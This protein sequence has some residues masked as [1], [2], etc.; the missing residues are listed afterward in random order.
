MRKRLF[1]S[2]IACTAGLMLVFSCT[3]KAP[4]A[5]NPGEEGSTPENPENPENP[6][7][8][9][10][11]K[12]PEIS[13]LS[14]SF[15]VAGNDADSKSLE[16]IS[17]YFFGGD[18]VMYKNETIVSSGGEVRFTAL[19]KTDAYFIAGASVPAESGI[20]RDDFLRMSIGNDIAHDNSAPEF[21]AAQAY[22]PDGEHAPDIVEFTRRTARIDMDTRSDAAMSISSITLKNVPSSA[23][24]FSSGSPEQAEKLSYSKIFDTPFSGKAEDLFRIYESSSPIGVVIAGTYG[25][26][27]VH[28]ETEI[29]SVRSNSIYTL[30]LRNAGSSFEG[31]FEISPWKDGGT[32]EGTPDTEHRILIDREYSEFPEGVSADF[33]SNAVEVPAEG[34]T[35]TLAFR[36][37]SE[38]RISSVNGQTSDVTVGDIQ[39]SRTETGIVSRYTVSIKPQGKGRLGYSVLMHLR[40]ALLDDTY[41]FVDIRVAQSPSQIHTVSLGG[42]VW[43]SFNASTRNLEDQVYTL[44]G[45]DVED[46]YR[47]DWTYCIGGLFQFGRMYMYIPWNSYNP[48]NDL[49]NQKQDIP[50]QS[51]THM[52]CPEGY[53]VPSPQ[54]W[55]SLLPA[56]TQVP[57]TYVTGAGETVRAELL[58]SES[59]INVPTGVTGT[60]RYVKLT[61]ESDGRYLIIPLAGN[62]GDKSTTNNPGFGQRAVMW[63][64]DNSGQYGGWARTHSIILSGSAANFQQTS[65][66]MEAFASVRCLKK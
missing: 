36:A 52:P 4:V 59:A 13:E 37:A 45:G 51:D 42:S 49:G 6:E 28:I 9:G 38:I 58:T 21:L 22:L 27:P 61:A 24:P 33:S 10:S 65:L 1:R 63:T 54:E 64:N 57:G 55:N 35:M 8:P 32:I 26:L 2:I 40:N 12:E 34:A 19:P 7:D 43:M 15:T 46:M 48:S 47:T 30:S 41:D 16:E 23:F 60:P 56:G 18:G 17:A 31:I 53:R 50:W 66:Q 20:L 29:P 62:K 44:D 3:E 39:V 5:G 25:N 11:G 14:F